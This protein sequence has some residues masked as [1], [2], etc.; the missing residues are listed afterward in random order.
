MLE[1]ACLLHVETRTKVGGEIVTVRKLEQRAGYIALKP[2]VRSHTACQAEA[3]AWF[4][5]KKSA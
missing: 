4:E 2:W 1:Q 3:R 5:R